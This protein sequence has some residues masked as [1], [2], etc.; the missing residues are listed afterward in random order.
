MFVSR[1]LSAVDAIA[2]ARPL[3]WRATSGCR[4]QQVTLAN[5]LALTV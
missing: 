4:V 1:A 3:H 2:K 5:L